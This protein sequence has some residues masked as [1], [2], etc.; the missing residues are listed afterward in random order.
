MCIKYITYIFS[1]T[2][3]P[4]VCESW[5]IIKP[6]KNEKIIQCPLVKSPPFY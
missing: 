5:H 3:R 6:K 1:I 4:H 2:I